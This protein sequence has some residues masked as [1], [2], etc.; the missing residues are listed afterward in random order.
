MMQAPDMQLLAGVCSSAE[1]F[2]PTS[3]DQDRVRV[4][5]QNEARLLGQCA[6]I[7]S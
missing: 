5:T 7:I 3:M 2:S 1:H 6:A 4:L